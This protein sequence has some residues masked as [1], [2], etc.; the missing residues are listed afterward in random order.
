MRDEY[1]NVSILRAAF[2]DIWRVGE[3]QPPRPSSFAI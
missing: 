1:G 2:I 3:E